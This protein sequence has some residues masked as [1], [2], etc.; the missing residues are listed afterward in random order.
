MWWAAEFAAPSDA[1]PLVT[2]VYRNAERYPFQPPGAPG[3]DV[4]GDGR[5][6]NQILGHFEIHRIQ[7]SATGALEDFVAT[8][9]QYCEMNPSD[10]LRGCVRYT[11]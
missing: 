9:E 4:S 1:G 10:V 11:P 7:V 3:I 2:Q 6:C 5:G 8:F